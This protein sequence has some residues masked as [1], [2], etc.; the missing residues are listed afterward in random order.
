MNKHTHENQ[1]GNFR[2]L[3]PNAC[4]SYEKN[5]AKH[6]MRNEELERL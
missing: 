3:S 6:L 1:R 4:E 2:G 5:T